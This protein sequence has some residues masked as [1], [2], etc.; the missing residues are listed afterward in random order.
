MGCCDLFDQCPFPREFMHRQSSI[1]QNLI[2]A[3]CRGPLY[4]RCQRRRVFLDTEVFPPQTLFPS[5]PV[6]EQFLRIE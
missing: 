6:P 3:Y 4:D 5:G 1:W 2:S